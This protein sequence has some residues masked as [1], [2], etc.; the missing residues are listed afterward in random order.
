MSLSVNGLGSEWRRVARRS[1]IIIYILSICINFAEIDGYVTVPTCDCISERILR[2]WI[3][4]ILSSV[5]TRTFCWIGDKVFINRLKIV[6]KYGIG[7]LGDY[8]RNICD[9]FIET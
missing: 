7:I 4:D 5:L 3:L 2:D 6:C 8:K 9:R 1:I